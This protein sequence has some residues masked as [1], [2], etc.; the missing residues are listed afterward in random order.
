MKDLRQTRDGKIT[1]GHMLARAMKA[2]GIDRIFSLCGGFINPIYM[3]CLDHNIEV[4][5][6]RNEMEAGFLATATTRT[7]RKP[8]VCL[9]EPSGFTNYISAVAEA[10]YA[11]DPV[12]FISATANSNNFDNAGFKE[13]PQAEVTDCMTKYSIE[14]NDP[15]R[16]GWFFDK[17][18]DIAIQHPTGPVQLCIPTNFLFTGRLDALPPEGARTF[19]PTRRKVHR[20]YP[21]PDDMDDVVATLQAAKKPV[22]IAGPGVWYSEA[23]NALEQFCD[24]Y[25]I[26]IFLPLTHV[27]S[28]DMSHRCNAGL[29]DYYQNL[30]SR[31][32]GEEADVVL[33]LGAQLDFPVNFGEAPLINPDSKLIMVNATAR[34]LSNTALADMRICCDIQMFV[35]ALNQ[36]D[37]V[38]PNVAPDWLTRIQNCRRG[39][40]LAPFRDILNGDSQASMHPLR[41]CYDVLMSL[42]ENDIC[43]IDGGDI[44]SWFEIAINAWSEAGR[45]IKGVIAPGPWEQMGTG[46]AFATA[47]QMAHPESR[48]VLITGDGSYGLAPGFTPMETAVDYEVPVTIVVANNAQ[49]GMIQNQQK[50]MWAGKV[51]ATSLR[52]MNYYPIMQ[53]A[54]VDAQQVTAGSELRDAVQT[55]M[56]KNV[57]CFIEVKTEAVPSP[58][59]QGLVDM[60]VRTAIE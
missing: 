6:T 20:P 47:V 3:G 21:H 59:T 56:G 16:I 44:A 57:P 8:S 24:T 30:G 5:G 33:F 9:A 11:G 4:V 41:L 1:G 39:E 37:G 42:G 22:I 25:N 10:Y 2:K 38:A 53:A 45:K 52:E 54:G 29:I 31:L 43:V 46:P 51:V 40:G 23:E 13:M 7:T 17:A 36:S 26:P 58:I 19:D 28:V 60:R 15:Q 18:Y 27:K 34:E 35:K 49:W 48:V 32:V 14:V 55:A 12:I 50:A